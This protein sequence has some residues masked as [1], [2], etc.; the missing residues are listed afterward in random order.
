MVRS[1]HIALIKDVLEELLRRS[2]KL[3]LIISR[4]CHLLHSVRLMVAEA[5]MVEAVERALLAH[6]AAEVRLAI[7]KHSRGTT[8]GLEDCLRTVGGSP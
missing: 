6:D 5:R 8:R 2:P 1:L 3:L 7:T 4:G